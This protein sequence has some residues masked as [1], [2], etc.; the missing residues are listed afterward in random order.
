[1][2]FKIDIQNIP[3]RIKNCVRTLIKN[4]YFRFY[5]LRPK[6]LDLQITKRNGVL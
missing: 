2:P 4:P 6:R 3:N 1:M 5:Y